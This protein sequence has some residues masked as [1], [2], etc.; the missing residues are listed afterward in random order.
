MKWICSIL[1]KIM[2][3]CTLT[4]ATAPA[5]CVTTNIP[6]ASDVGM[7]N[8]GE[9]GSWTTENNKKR[10]IS[11]IQ[12]DLTQFRGNETTQNAGAYVPIEAKVGLSFMN[13]F[14]HIAKVLDSSLVRFTIIFIIIAF[15]FWLFFEAYTIISGQSKTDEKIKEIA[16]NGLKVVMWVAVLSFGPTEIFM[17]L[18]K[19][20]LYIGTWFSDAILEAAKSFINEDTLP[21]TCDAIKQYAATNISPENILKPDEAASIMCLPTRLS[22]FCRTA[23]GIGWDWLSGGLGNSVFSFMCG[24][25]LI[26]GF[27]YLGWKFAFIAFGVIADLFLGI[28]MLPF[29][30]IAETTAKTTYKGIAGNIFNGFLKLFSTETLNAQISR[31]INATLHFFTLSVIIAICAA[32]LSTAINTNNPEMIPQLNDQNTWMNM[33]IFALT[34]WLAKK[35]SDLASEIG[36]KISYDMGSALQ[37]DA[38]GALSG[39]KNGLKSFIKIIRNR[40]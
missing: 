2:L 7:P 35:A 9:Y 38:E 17:S 5:L 19:P 31:F 14:S 13:A 27:I 28:I 37:K 10:Y 23:I 11:S 30:A 24:L 22:G 6:S 40:K 21:N 39:A 26:I 25:A 32:L 29:T 18:M 12:K 8:I 1:S 20:I 36:G 33:F 34:W 3:A 4:F 16:K 15:G